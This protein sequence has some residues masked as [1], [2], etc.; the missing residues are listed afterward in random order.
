MS[1]RIKITRNAT[2]LNHVFRLRHNV[3]VEQEGVYDTRHDDATSLVDRFDA[4]PPVA[5]IIAYSGQVP[6][7]TLRMNLDTGEGLPP[8]ELYDFTEYRRSVA[9]EWMQ[10]RITP[11]RFMSGG[12]LAISE[13]WRT[14]RDVLRALFKVGAGVGRLWN[15]TH[16]I[17]T[18]SAKTASIYSR[19][20]FSAVG[21]ERWIE[22]IGDHILPMA[23]LFD[24]YY[25][26]AFGDLTEH[27]YSLNAFS[28]RFQR[29]ILTAGEVLFKEGELGD[30]A[31]IIDSGTI[32][33]SQTRI[34]D[35]EQTLATFGR[36]ELFGELSLLDQ[37][38][39]S[40]QATAI[41]NTELIAIN[42][43][44]FQ[45]EIKEHPENMDSLLSFFSARIRRADELIAALQGTV[46]HR[47]EHV[48]EDLR[49]TAMPDPKEPSKLIAKVGIETFVHCAD[50]TEKEAKEFLGNQAREKH[51][52]FTGG[53]IRFPAN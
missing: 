16:I 2:E 1:V 36:G 10:I 43:R 20:G 41:T 52:E 46:L 5:N 40:A 29:I 38:R 18:V 49:N 19:L 14:R 13:A 3:Y 42:R 37:K 28:E 7:G 23:A 33:I 21:E 17:A 8:D 50:V 45:R 53:Y 24:D 27:K 34:S 32:R 6:I 35:R 11:P 30:E 26:W 12:M 15:A 31:Y 9:E 47:M 4:F 39:R 25:A 22:D 51:I 48:L 44:D